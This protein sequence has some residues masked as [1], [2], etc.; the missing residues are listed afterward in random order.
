MQHLALF[1]SNCLPF[2][3]FLHTEAAKH[4]PIHVVYTYAH[5]GKKTRDKA[6]IAALI[7]VVAGWTGK[8]LLQEK[9]QQSFNV[10]SFHFHG[11]QKP[12]AYLKNIS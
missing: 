8:N 5:Y 1:P 9:E 11:L 3:T 6:E 2:Y 7:Q 12:I 10:I 4:M